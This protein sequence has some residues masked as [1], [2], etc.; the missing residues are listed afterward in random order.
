MRAGYGLFY[1]SIFYPSW[2]GGISWDGFNTNASF[3]SSQGGLQPAFVL[4]QGFPQNFP[5]PPLIDSAADNG[6][7]SIFYRPFDADRLPYSQQ[8]NLTLEHQFT[9]NFYVNAAYVANK[10]TRLNSQTLPINALDPSLL[11]MGQKL[12][13][14]FQSGQTVLDGVPIP[15]P[16]WLEQMTACAPAVAQALTPYPQYCSP[17]R[18]ANE[19][20]GSST[21]HSFQL[22]AENRFSHG[23]WFLGAYTPSKLL[24]NADS[25]QTDAT[26]PAPAMRQPAVR[27]ATAMLRKRRGLESNPSSSAAPAVS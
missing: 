15:Y 18:G 5:H 7:G 8:W 22:K 11:A 14:V 26:R 17:L 16:G 23:L 9:N 2:N 27:V 3:S 10:G 19:N 6:L 12:Y 13:D 25:V 1:S 4:S 20:L 24:T 21:Y